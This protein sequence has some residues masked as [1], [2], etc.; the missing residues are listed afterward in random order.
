MSEGNSGERSCKIRLSIMLKTAFRNLRRASFQVREEGDRRPENW[1][2]G[3]S[4]K[5]NDRRETLAGDAF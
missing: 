5:R 3:L 2:G 1:F 4:T